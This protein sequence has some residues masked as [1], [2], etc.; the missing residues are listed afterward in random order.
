MVDSIYQTHSLGV[1][2]EGLPDQYADDRAA[3]VWQLYIGDMRSR[4]T[5]YKNWLV[6]LLC[7]QR[8]NTVLDM[9]CGTR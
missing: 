5:K 4:T 3:W 2:A 1:A 8:S 6:S 7:A 9:A